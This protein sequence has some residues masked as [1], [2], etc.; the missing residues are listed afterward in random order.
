MSHDKIL[1]PT[2][3]AAKGKQYVPLAHTGSQV[4]AAGVYS[5]I[6]NPFTERTDSLFGTP[7]RTRTCDLLV[8]SQTLYPTELRVRRITKT[9]LELQYFI[10]LYV[11]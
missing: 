6:K 1:A 3:G 8:R 11:E 9:S 10:I 2:R 5:Q 7:G 4:R